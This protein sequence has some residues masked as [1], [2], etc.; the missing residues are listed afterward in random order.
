LVG[1]KYH[2]AVLNELETAGAY[3]GEAGA[4]S[5]FVI[6]VEESHGILV[7]PEVRDK[8]AAGAAVLLAELASGMRDEGRTVGDYLDDLY[9]RYGYY[10]THLSSMVMD[11]AK[12]VDAIQK[13]QESLRKTPPERIGDLRVTQVVDHLDEGGAHGPWKSETDR[14]SRNV[15]VFRLENGARII[16]RPSGTEPKN[17]TYVELPRAPLGTDASEADLREE[18]SRA[19]EQAEAIADDFS[20]HSLSIVGVDLPRYAL[21]ISGLVELGRR[22][23]FVEN[24]LPELEQRTHAVASGDGS[25]EA[26]G[27]WVDERLAR[28]GP[29]ARGL[30]RRA[31]HEFVDETR[32]KIDTT[33]E[34]AAALEVIL[35]IFG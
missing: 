28:Y 34:R 33:A 32:S 18:R 26:I 35:G 30:V 21:H 10:A 2:G 5:D 1:F 3:R 24:F 6:A 25:S 9:R 14:T 8:D 23:D 20:Q 12:G 15:L 4:L 13:I 17:K 27:A 11:G 31:V 7:T 19:I 29:D 16:I 22:I